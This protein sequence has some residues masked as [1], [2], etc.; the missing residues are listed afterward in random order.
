MQAQLEII[1]SGFKYSRTFYSLPSFLEAAKKFGQK[2]FEETYCRTQPAL[3]TPSQEA[4]RQL[5]RRKLFNKKPSLIFGVAKQ[6][7]AAVA[8]KQ[9]TGT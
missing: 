8:D 6:Y 9:N 7:Q 5:S 4:G 1:I 2:F 3:R